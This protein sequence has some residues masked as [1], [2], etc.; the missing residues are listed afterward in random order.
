MKMTAAHLSFIHFITARGARL[1]NV[2]EVVEVI[3]MVWL[4]RDSDAV[5]SAYY[6]GLLNYRGQIISVFDPAGNAQNFLPSPEGFLI[7]SSNGQQ[8]IAL[9]ADEV[10]Q[11]VEI[12][13]ES[14]REISAI[15]Q[16]AF[17]AAKV[18]GQI[19]RI[20]TTA[21]YLQRA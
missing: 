12:D 4:E 14:V 19:I 6:I 10:N 13:T 21:D 17:S 2:S 1:I 18:N 20:V 5:E 9:L 7:V 16:Q 11:L 3:P 15:D 8:T